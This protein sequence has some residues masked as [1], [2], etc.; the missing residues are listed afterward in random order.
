MLALAFTLLFSFFLNTEIELNY[1]YFGNSDLVGVGNI[2]NG[3][4]SGEWRV[5]SKINPDHSNQ[6]TF[7]AVDPET[8]KRL[9]NQELPVY[10][11]YFSEDLPNGIFQE[12]YPTGSIKTLATLENGKLDGDFKEFFENGEKKYSGQYEDGKKVEEWQEYFESGQIKS[13]IAYK[14]G[15]ANGSALYY[16]PDGNLE[17]K[18]SYSKGEID[19]LYEAYFTDGDL[20]EKGMFKNGFPEGEWISINSDRKTKLNGNYLGG[21]RSGEWQEIFE[22]LPGYSRQGNYHK[23]LK[24][25]DWLV[26]DEKGNHVQTENY[27]EG[28]LASVIEVQNADQLKNQQILKKGNGQRII[29]DDQGFVLA[30]GKVLKGENNG[31]WSYYF[32]NSNRL[33]SSGKLLGTKRV[34]VWKFYNFQGEVIDEIEYKEKPQSGHD[35]NGVGTPNYYRLNPATNHDALGSAYEKFYPFNQY[36]IGN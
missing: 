25:G 5:Y 3:K 13:T 24:E 26:I 10:I 34:G 14:D 35:L 2:E 15:L 4:K 12:N 33:A 9:F 1:Y 17:F 28:K 29:F 23:G 18:L 32:P 22:I 6:S 8:F 27:L 36:R 31:N 7:E 21:I 19:G 20:K 30:K 16:Y 11:I